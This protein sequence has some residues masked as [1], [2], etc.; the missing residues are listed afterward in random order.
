MIW[1]LVLNSA[2][3]PYKAVY[4][5]LCLK[6]REITPKTTRQK[7]NSSS[8]VIIGITSL[9]WEVTNRQ[10]ATPVI[11][12]HTPYRSA[13]GFFIQTS[14]LRGN[15]SYGAP[16]GLPRMNFLDFHQLD[17]ACLAGHANREDSSAQRT[18]PRVSLCSVS[19]I[20]ISLYAGVLATGRLGAYPDW[21]FISGI[22]RA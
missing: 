19:T 17:N 5:F 8:Q 6:H 21:T 16:W 4:L 1:R 22:M 18:V 9:H 10:T 20:G 15:P 12:Y 3:P 13:W 11:L 2:R 7:L 14:I